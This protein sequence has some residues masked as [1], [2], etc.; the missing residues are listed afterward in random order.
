MRKLSPLERSIVK[1]IVAQTSADITKFDIVLRDN[2]FNATYNMAFLFG[3][4]ASQNI[5]AILYIE[6]CDEYSS[7]IK[8]SQFLEVVSLIKYLEENRMINILQNEIKIESSYLSIIHQGW[9]IQNFD[10]NMNLPLNTD[11]LYW[12]HTDY[13]IKDIDG[14]VIYKPILLPEEYRNFGLKYLLTAIYSTEEL[15]K[16]V[17][18]DFLTEEE[19]ALLI[20]QQS[21]I[22]TQQSLSLTQDALKATKKSL[23]WTKYAFVVSI[24]ALLIGAFSYNWS[25]STIQEKQ[26]N[27]MGDRNLQLIKKIEDQTFEISRRLDS[28]QGIGPYILPLNV[29][30][31]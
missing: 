22:L 10:K 12:D 26:F 7:R 4:S 8:I 25:T 24:G 19:E 13:N 15:R 29:D 9:N 30:K 3:F 1:L 14:K 23:K 27:I 21:L 6:E 2:F 16:I 20:S 11:G 28:I 18:R 17:Q 31:K 5:P